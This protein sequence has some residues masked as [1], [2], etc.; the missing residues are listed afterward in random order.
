VTLRRS[1]W[2]GVAGTVGLWA[3]A[4]SPGHALVVNPARTE[5]RLT[6]GTSAQVT[7]TVTNDD[8]VAVQVDVSKKDWFIPDVNKVW[9]VKRC[10][11]VR[12][13]AKFVLEPGASRP[14]EVELFC[15]QELDGEVVGMVSFLYR[16]E[17]ASMV[18][19]MISVSMYVIAEGREKLAGE[20]Q[21]IQVR[22]YR[23]QTSLNV[24]LKATGNVHVRPSGRLLI[25]DKKG[26]EV[27]AVPV[28]EGPPTYPGRENMYGG[29][30]PAGT[31]L[32]KGKYRVHVDLTYRGLDLKADRAFKVRGDG[33]VEMM[34]KK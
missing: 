11:E 30:V 23:D 24:T 6:P 29:P 15:P 20:L 9:I 16:G 19:P 27:A 14:V 28:P 33:Q 21:D 34:D 22:R 2:M 12:V 4:A 7:L 3:G 13:R 26:K 8:K 32:G 31:A 18:T 17:Q 5:V 1:L 25:I 10:L